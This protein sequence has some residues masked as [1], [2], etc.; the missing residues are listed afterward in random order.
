M[1]CRSG[2]PVAR[3]TI[4]TELGSNTPGSFACPRID[5]KSTSTSM[6]IVPAGKGEV[7]STGSTMTT[8]LEAVTVRGSKAVRSKRRLWSGHRLDRCWFDL[9]V[10]E[11]LMIGRN[12]FLGQ[13][14]FSHHPV[15]RN[16]DCSL[17]A[18]FRATRGLAHD[19]A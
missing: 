11:E 13:L 5:A 1:A 12:A 16:R 3:F 14:L 19:A 18:R 6:G 4:S 15:F 8:A 9:G 17:G 10:E 7:T 2:A